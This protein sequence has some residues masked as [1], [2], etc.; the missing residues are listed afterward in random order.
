MGA[1]LVEGN[2]I[3]MGL[4]D[5]QEEVFVAHPGKTEFL[6]LL[7]QGCEIVDFVFFDARNIALGLPRKRSF[8]EE[9]RPWLG[10]WHTLAIKSARRTR[11]QPVDSKGFFIEEVG[12]AQ[13]LVHAVVH[14]F[15]LQCRRINAQFCKQSACLFAVGKGRVNRNRAAVG[16]QEPVIRTKLTPLC[17]TVKVAVVVEDKNANAAP[18]KFA[19]IL[20]S[21]PSAPGT[22]N[23]N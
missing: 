17:R 16:E 2:D 8:G 14:T 9:I 15:L 6:L 22:A 3:G 21:I 19:I 23:N 4:D 11:Y 7:R 10:V 18:F 12:P 20:R 5:L 13:S 1:S